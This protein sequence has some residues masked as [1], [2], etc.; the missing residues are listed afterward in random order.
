MG[1]LFKAVVSGFGFSVGAAA[2]KKLSNTL[3]LDE[4]GKSTDTAKS[5]ASD[6]GEL[7]ENVHEDAP[8]MD[9]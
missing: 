9:W 6:D 4:E 2:F 3:G 1:V 7:G 8:E 5:D